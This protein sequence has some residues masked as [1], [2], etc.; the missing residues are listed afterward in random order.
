MSLVIGSGSKGKQACMCDGDDE[1]AYTVHTVKCTY[2]EILIQCIYT[3]H[4]LEYL[5]NPLK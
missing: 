3:V 4:T 2:T 1:K 5:C